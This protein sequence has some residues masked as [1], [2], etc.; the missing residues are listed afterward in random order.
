MADVVATPETP[1]T[2]APQADRQA[3]ETKLGVPGFRASRVVG[4]SVRLSV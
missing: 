3:D 2:P 4:G 1:P